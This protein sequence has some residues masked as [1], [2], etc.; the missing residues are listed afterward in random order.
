MPLKVTVPPAIKRQ[1]PHVDDVTDWR[2]Q[3]SLRRLVDRVCDL[4]A[5]LQ[6]VEGTLVDLVSANAAHEADLARVE[7]A[8]GEALALAQRLEHELDD[9]PVTP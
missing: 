6:G 9:E 5:R 7:R 2:A 1:Y 4:E 8:V 3:Q